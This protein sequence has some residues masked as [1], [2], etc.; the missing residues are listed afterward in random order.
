MN[1]NV[2]WKDIKMKVL[3]WQQLSLNMNLTIQIHKQV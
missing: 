1:D 3:V 2:E